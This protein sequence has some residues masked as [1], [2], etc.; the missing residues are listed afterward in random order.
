LEGVFLWKFQTQPNILSIIYR[1]KEF[2][3]GR[4]TS[5]QQEASKRLVCV[6]GCVLE[7]ERE[8]ERGGEGGRL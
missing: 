7:R 8:R 3:G 6:C 4:K 5:R 1:G 2:W